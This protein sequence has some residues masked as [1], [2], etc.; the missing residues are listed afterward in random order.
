MRRNREEDPQPDAKRIPA[1]HT[2]H[3]IETFAN[4]DMYSY[5]VS[6]DLD[7]ELDAD[8]KLDH[9]IE[10]DLKLHVRPIEILNEIKRSKWFVKRSCVFPSA[11]EEKRKHE[12][13]M[14]TALLLGIIHVV[15]E[16]VIF[17]VDQLKARLDANFDQTC[18]FNTFAGAIEM[19]LN[20]SAE[21]SILLIKLL[22]DFDGRK[23]NGF[24]LVENRKDSNI[25]TC[26]INIIMNLYVRDQDDHESNITKAMWKFLS[27]ASTVLDIHRPY[28][29]TFLINEAIRSLRFRCPP[30]VTV[31]TRFSD[32]DICHTF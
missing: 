26:L 31:T 29:S 16:K 7:C 15:K 8:E 25:K 3:I 1:S 32:I 28:W 6:D 24:D 2:K 19:L 21:S 30:N 5:C 11:L 4:V 22:D 12:R 27:S 9:A 20:E 17:Y 18:M 23:P 10:L 14:D 13:S